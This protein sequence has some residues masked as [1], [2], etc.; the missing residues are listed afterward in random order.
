MNPRKLLC[1]LVFQ[2]L[3]R[4]RHAREP[5]CS[6]SPSAGTSEPVAQS[7]ALVA[8]ACTL[9]FIAQDQLSRQLRHGPPPNGTGSSSTLQPIT[10][11]NQPITVLTW[12]SRANRPA[13]ATGA[14]KA[15]PVK[16]PSAQK[17]S[18]VRRC[19][20]RPDRSR[21]GLIAIAS[22]PASALAEPPSIRRCAAHA[23]PTRR[24]FISD[25]I[26]RIRPDGAAAPRCR[27]TVSGR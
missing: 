7:S 20:P 14:C 24:R 23:T 5:V 19:R 17:N 10:V 4:T 12:H 11:L 26:S 21:R 6:D 8:A 13:G 9:S 18:G 15:T 16:T 2:P 22:P 25:A 3:A 1:R 27:I